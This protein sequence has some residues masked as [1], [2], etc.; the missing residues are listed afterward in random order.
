MNQSPDDLPKELIHLLSV[1]SY[2]AL[3][4]NNPPAHSTLATENRSVSPPERRKKQRPRKIWIDLE[5]SPHIPFFAPIIREL[6]RRG[7]SIVLTAR[8][9]FQVRELA[10]LF[11]LQYLL[12]GHHYGKH[13]VAKLAG[14]GVRAV[15]M[16]PYAL[17]EKP[18]L[19]L[20]HGSRSQFLLSTMLGIPTVTILDYEHARWKVAS[21]SSWT[22]APDVIPE[23]SLLAMGYTKDRILRYP[24]IKEDV[25]APLFSPDPSV[26]TR[27]RLREEDL[28][29]TI[30]PPASEAH[31]HNPESDTLLSAVFEIVSQHREAKVILL[32][33]TPRQETELRKHWPEFF[34]TGKIV[35]P[36]QVI[37]GM[38]L[39]WCSDLVISGGGTMNREAAAL[40][41][42]VYSIFRGKT[43][44]IDEYL[45]A[46]GRLVM[47]TSIEDVRHKLKLIRRQMNGGPEINRSCTLQTIVENIIQV[48][49]A[50]LWSRAQ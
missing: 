30:R 10:D 35:V 15:Q 41:V 25:Y 34:A 45:G 28:V 39:I 31:Y 48:A 33:R 24:G 2:P 32:P 26:R 14:L 36:A 5:N 12:M 37:D 46:N 3:P 29:V 19:S 11:G 47:L 16:I 17:R 4:A 8:D 21:R 50:C 27:L 23:S 44:A 1:K 20:S 7:Y 42:P 38:D 43:G 6:E 18:T 9:C 22:M 49:E 40:G 13:T